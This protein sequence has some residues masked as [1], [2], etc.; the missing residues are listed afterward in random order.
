MSPRRLALP[1]LAVGALLLAL[2]GCAPAASERSEPQVA[3][4]NGPAQGRIRGSAELLQSEM[5]NQGPL[6]FTFVNSAAM[7]FAEVHNDM[8]Y[9]RAATAAARIARS[10]RAPYAVV[11]G[12]STLQRDVTVSKDKATRIVAVT[13]Q[14][15]AVVVDASNDKVVA[16]VDSQLMQQSRGESTDEPLPSLQN[17]PTVLALRNEGVTDIAPAVLRALRHA[18]R[19]HPNG[20]PQARAYPP[21]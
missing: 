14:I 6:G 4:L 18:L 11:V 16:R 3:V 7:R 17:D 12:A 10:Y 9:D 1:I 8:F 15:E 5:A 13:L 2:A 20:Q 19:A 21:A